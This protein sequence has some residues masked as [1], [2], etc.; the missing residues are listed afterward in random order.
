MR[1]LG[2]VLLV[3]LMAAAIGCGGKGGVGEADYAE[4]EVAAE[5]ATAAASEAE[6]E[7]AAVVESIGSATMKEDGTLVLQLRA[8]GEGGMIGDA[9]ITYAPDDERYADT[10][11]HLGGLAPGESKPVPPWPEE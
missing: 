2:S 3:V 11:E 9:Y 7:K 10:L 8:E 1:S 5:P 4:P 6:P